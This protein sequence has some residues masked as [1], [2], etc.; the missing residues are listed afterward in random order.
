MER[1]EK[2][3]GPGRPPNHRP[4][5]NVETGTVH[6]TYASAARE[7]DGHRNKVYLCAIG[8]QKHHHGYHFEFV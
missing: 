1:E 6:K 8:I 2:R 4:V 5:K 7:I 3:K